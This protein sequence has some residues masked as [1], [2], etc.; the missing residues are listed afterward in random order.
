MNLLLLLAAA[1][2]LPSV[3]SMIALLVWVAIAAIVIW[4]VIA[5]VRWS[6]LPIPQ[7]VWIILTA[8][9]GIVCIVFIARFFGVAV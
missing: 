1:G 3:S 8:I 2:G 4:G 9:V 6:Q 7:P 5:L